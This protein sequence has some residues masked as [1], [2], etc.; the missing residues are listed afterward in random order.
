MGMAMRARATGRRCWPARPCWPA[1]PATSR[2]RT[3]WAWRRAARPRRASRI[4]PRGR[5]PTRRVS[6]S[7]AA[8]AATSRERPSG[9]PASAACS[10]RSRSWTRPR[11]ARS[12]LSAR[13]SERPGAQQPPSS[14]SSRPQGSGAGW[15]VG[16]RGGAG[17]ALL[18][19]HRR[20]VGR[21]LRA[22]AA[23]RGGPADERAHPRV[24]ARRGAVAVRGA[25][26]RPG[27]APVEGT[28]GVGVGEELRRAGAPLEPAAPADAH[29]AL[30]LTPLGAVE[31]DQVED[32]ADL[33]VE[34]RARPARA[35][36][37]VDPPR[38]LAEHATDELRE[39][40][41]RPC[42]RS[43]GGRGRAAPWCGA[44][45]GGTCRGPACRARRSA[46]ADGPGR[47]PAPDQPA[48][49]PLPGR[50][51]SAPA[52][53]QSTCGRRSVRVSSAPGAAPSESS[54]ATISLGR[55]QPV[56]LSSSSGTPGGSPGPPTST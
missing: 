8:T 28:G 37:D 23:R 19:D 45:S 10:P 7:A 47:H 49:A 52:P 50:W 21:R 56:R 5:A 20:R 44:A 38:P 46:P 31:D 4:P 3:S 15:S 11:D 35:G 22:L 54:L 39:S 6:S 43:A 26:Q 9:P 13:R 30:E 27:Q 14:F 25:R 36:P 18:V 34:D 32:V 41:D 53:G 42:G 33:V 51:P 40:A 17:G 1:A 48:H 2:A 29:D 12:R 24:A 55:P 16:G